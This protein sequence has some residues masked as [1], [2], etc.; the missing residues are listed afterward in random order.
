[1]A[2]K[3]GLPDVI[4]SLFHL[5]ESILEAYRSE[6]EKSSGPSSQPLAVAA[7]SP[8]VATTAP[9]P[10]VAA[11]APSPS[12]VAATPSTSKKITYQQGL[13]PSSKNKSASYLRNFINIFKAIE[14]TPGRPLKPEYLKSLDGNR[15]YDVVI[16]ERFL[17]AISNQSLGYI[18][19]VRILKAK[20]RTSAANIQHNNVISYLA[21]TFDNMQKEIADLQVFTAVL[22]Q[23]GNTG[24]EL[25][26]QTDYGK[27]V[28]EIEESA[29][30]VKQEL[31]ALQGL[32]K[33]IDNSATFSRP[34][35]LVPFL[36]SQHFQLFVARFDTSEVCIYDNEGGK[37][38]K[39][40]RIT[41]AG[42]LAWALQVFT[43]KTFTIVPDKLPSDKKRD[44][45]TEC[46][47]FVC[48]HAAILLYG[49]QDIIEK[50]N[51]KDAHGFRLQVKQ[52]VSWSTAR[53]QT[54]N[55]QMAKANQLI[56]V[57][58]DDASDEEKDVEPKKP[59]I[60]SSIDDLLCDE[61][62]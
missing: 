10:S 47:P 15:W 29:N 62:V 9:S 61:D 33:I 20:T 59:K 6:S 44:S 31:D 25:E 11:T 2:K 24:I 22:Q 14:L 13:K 36:W 52:V 55:S 54:R 8:S 56:N 28:S 27:R 4:F 21:T 43:N 50:L 48:I 3:N 16:I 1:M 46:G 42:A 40:E 7:P 53:Q 30:F 39:T 51:T 5:P 34:I 41:H 45:E 32:Q 19:L 12:V 23:A 37:Y 58:V 60:S 18:E 38:A 26:P 49:D 35:C 57:L 17:K